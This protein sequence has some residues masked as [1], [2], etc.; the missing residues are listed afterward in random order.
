[1]E[2][3]RSTRSTVYRAS[4]WNSAYAHCDET[5]VTGIRR[6]VLESEEVGDNVIA[7]LARVR[8]H[9]EAVRKIVARLAG[10]APAER[11]TA[12]EQLFILAGLRQLEET[13]EREVRKMPVYIDILENKVRA[14]IQEGASGRPAGRRSR[15][16]SPPDRKALWSAA[17]V[18]R[19]A[20]G[21][22]IH[23]TT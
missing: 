15:D 11:A 21:G 17:I 2:E 23:R 19:R 8:D 1:M 16:S 3:I 20:A 6:S 12:L 10:L 5:R 9:K 18:G 7:I 14:G 4:G 22:R 13:V